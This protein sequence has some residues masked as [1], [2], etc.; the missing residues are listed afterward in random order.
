MTN[1]AAIQKLIFQ[2]RRRS[3]WQIL[4]EHFGWGLV[5]GLGALLV[6]MLVGT[7]I[8]NWYWPVLLVGL[9]VAI[10]WWRSRKKLPGEY[11]VACS[12]DRELGLR[13]LISTAHYFATPGRAKPEFVEAVQAAAES[14]AA[15]IDASVAVPLRTPRSTWPVAALLLASLTMFFVRY[16]VLH[17]FDLRAPIAEVRFDTLT[18]VPA[19]VKNAPKELAQKGMPAEPFS[20][21]LPESERVEVME[22]DNMTQ[23][24]LRSVDVKDPDKAT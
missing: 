8:L 13:D 3:V 1:T 21:T 5:A 10:G 22:R 24:S 18:G 23:E 16:G 20:L 6:L 9:T 2:A 12:V 4:L 11:E 7:Q 17:T 15:G 14:T 19:P